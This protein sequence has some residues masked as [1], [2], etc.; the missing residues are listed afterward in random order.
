MGCCK[1]NKS[2]LRKSYLTLD[3]ERLMRACEGSE[4]FT[5]FCF[6]CLFNWRAIQN[7]GSM[8]KGLLCVHTIRRKS[9]EIVARHA[10]ARFA[11]N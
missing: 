10:L 7:P 11:N 8:G 4:I 1:K 9:T 5:F 3:F 6:G 2:I